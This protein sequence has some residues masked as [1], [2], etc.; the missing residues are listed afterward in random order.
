MPFKGAPFYLSTH[1]NMMNLLLRK[2]LHELH[3]S[4]CNLNG[5]TSDPNTLQVAENGNDNP[6]RGASFC[7]IF[8]QRHYEGAAGPDGTS[9]V[10]DISFSVAKDYL[11]THTVAPLRVPADSAVGDRR[12]QHLDGVWSEISAWFGTLLEAVQKHVS[13]LYQVVGCRQ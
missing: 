11:P 10:A 3:K 6:F 9:C 5:H 8:V 1:M 4:V 7:T 13:K 12:P 2:H